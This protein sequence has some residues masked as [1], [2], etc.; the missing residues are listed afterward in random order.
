[1]TFAHSESRKLAIAFFFFW[2]YWF[3]FD[4]VRVVPN[5]LFN[6]VH[7]LEPYELEKSLFGIMHNGALLT[8]NEWFGQHLN[9]TIDLVCGIFYLGW[10]PIPMLF[11]IYIFFKKRE[12]CYEFWYL[13][14]IAN[15]IGFIGYYTYPAAPPWYYESFGTTFIAETPSNAARLLRVDEILGFPLF[16]DMYD[17]GSS[18]FA[19][20]PSMHS[21]FPVLLLYIGR[22]A[23]EYVWTF[24]FLI[25]LLGIWFA[26]VYLNH[27]YIIDVLLGALTAIIAIVIYEWTRKRKPFN[28]ILQ[29]LHTWTAK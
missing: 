8:P 20:I 19:A 10:V 12:Y 15:M 4:S 14:W 18:V 1:M 16:E 24:V 21:A 29:R 3:I 6:D 5:Y 11:T 9:S 28:G 2:V 13:F 26:A 25:V 22:K 17:K 23:K 27:H 7:I